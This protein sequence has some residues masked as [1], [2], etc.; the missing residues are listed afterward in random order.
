MLNNFTG[1]G[2]DFLKF[3][4]SDKGALKTGFSVSSR[5]GSP[6]AKLSLKPLESY[7]SLIL[8]LGFF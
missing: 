7:S 8:I 2:E 6:K 5:V 1:G 4:G 3:I